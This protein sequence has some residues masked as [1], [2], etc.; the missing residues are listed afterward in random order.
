MKLHQVHVLNVR[1]YIYRVVCMQLTA[2]QYV[3]YALNLQSHHDAM[4]LVRHAS[5]GNFLPS[6]ELEKELICTLLLC[7]GDT[8]F[9]KEL[10]L[11]KFAPFGLT[12]H[13]SY[14]YIIR[15]HEFEI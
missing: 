4:A 15:S 8:C 7:N 11:V 1:I 6:N 5:Y 13:A 9:L 14:G 12:R 10:G 2:F 3:R